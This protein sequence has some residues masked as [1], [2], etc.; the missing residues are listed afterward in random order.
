MHR[1]LFALCLLTFSTAHVG[2]A[3][4]TTAPLPPGV[5]AVWDLSSAYREKTP[6]SE[7]VCLYGLLRV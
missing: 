2:L 4:Q 3:A 5:K 7:R 1:H 6:T